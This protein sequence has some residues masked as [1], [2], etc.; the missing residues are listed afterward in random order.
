MRKR[1]LISLAAIAVALLTSAGSWVLPGKGQHA[2]S[3]SGAE[4]RSISSTTYASRTNTTITAPTGIQNGDILIL[5]FVM[6][7]ASPPTATLPSGF[8]SLSGPTTVTR[9]SF[10]VSRHLAWKL[11]SSE[12]GDYTV[13]HSATASQG[14]I[15]CVSG[16]ANTT[17]VF[18]SNEAEGYA[19]GSGSTTTATGITTPSN[20]SLVA[21]IAHNWQLYGSASAPAGSTPTFTERLDAGTSI[22]YAATGVLATAGATG[23]KTHGNGNGV[24]DP[25]GVFLVSVGP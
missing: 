18:S 16:A 4:F 25:W 17:P 19:G 22:M 6:G 3:A 5:A 14:V 10:S 9:D 15:I 20:N 11:A 13:T 2:A 8:T 12:S 7:N 23:D 24:E 1:I 21:F